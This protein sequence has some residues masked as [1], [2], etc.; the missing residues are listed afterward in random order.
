MG[1]AHRTNLDGHWLIRTGARQGLPGLAQVQ[2]GMRTQNLLGAWYGLIQAVPVPVEAVIDPVAVSL[3]Q[4][5]IPNKGY[6]LCHQDGSHQSHQGP[7]H[8][9]QLGAHWLCA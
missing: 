4:Q 8:A 7:V 2:P 6:E 3:G 5:S 9:R 1:A